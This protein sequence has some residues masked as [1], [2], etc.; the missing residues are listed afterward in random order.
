VIASII[1][2]IIQDPPR[3]WGEE[4]R[5]N[6]KFATLGRYSELK[7]R[8]PPIVQSIITL[9]DMLDSQDGRLA[10]HVQPVWM[11]AKMC[12]PE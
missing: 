12:L 11:P 2:R 10:R 6:L 7:Q 5:E 4:Q 8:P 1:E 3:N 9:M